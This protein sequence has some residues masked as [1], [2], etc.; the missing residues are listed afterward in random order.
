MSY[1]DYFSLGCYAD[2]EGVL[3][4]SSCYFF[5]ESIESDS[6]SELYSV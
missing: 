2:A 4:V 5:V 6:W 1:T 3:Y